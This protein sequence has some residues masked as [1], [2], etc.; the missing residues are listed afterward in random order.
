VK[1]KRYYFED[2]E[3]E[4]DALGTFGSGCMFCGHEDHDKTRCPVRPNSD[5]V[6]T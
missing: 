5:W 2:E 1:P 4:S 6:K 3:P